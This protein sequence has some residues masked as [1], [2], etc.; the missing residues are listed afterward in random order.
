MS[1]ASWEAWAPPLAPPADGGLPR[2]EAQ[3]IADATWDEDRH[4]CAALQWDAYVATLPPS[5]PVAQ[6]STGMQSVSYGSA[7]PGGKLGEAMARAAWHWSFVSGFT[8]VP[9]EIA[10]PRARRYRVVRRFQAA[11]P[12]DRWF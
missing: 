1:P 7:M 2:D 6:V 8:S 10:A 12:Y 5:L 4:L 3:A 9:L 11:D